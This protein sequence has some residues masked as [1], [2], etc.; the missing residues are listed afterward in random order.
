MKPIRFIGDSLDR[1]RLFP[2]AVRHNAGYQLDKVQR[3][4]LPNDFKTMGAIGKGIEELRVRDETGAYRVIY[5]ARMEHAVYVL[6]AFKK[7]SRATAK[8]DV[9]LISKR[10]DKL[11]RASK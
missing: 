7:K 1:L 10:Y 11:I 5:Y 3:G 4:E 8:R 9:E 6:H 2:E